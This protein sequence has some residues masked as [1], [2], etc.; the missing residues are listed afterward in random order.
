[1][2]IPCFKEI[3][4]PTGWS[5]IQK[6]LTPKNTFSMNHPP[7]KLIL[8]KR[9]TH[10][11]PP[12]SGCLSWMGGKGWYQ[13]QGLKH[14]PLEGAGIIIQT[15]QKKTPQVP[16][17]HWKKSLVATPFLPPPKKKSHNNNNVPP[18]VQW[19]H[20]RLSSKHRCCSL[21]SETVSKFP[22][23]GFFGINF[24]ITKIQIP[25]RIHGT[26][27]FAAILPT[28]NG[29]IYPIL[30]SIPLDSW[31]DS[32]Q[33]TTPIIHW[34]SEFQTYNRYSR[35]KF[36]GAKPQTFITLGG[37]AKIRWKSSEWNS[38]NISTFQIL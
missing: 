15:P 32:L 16:F 1:M 36:Q 13:S 34:I 30:C 17:R 18:D 8:K 35:P 11:D 9:K 22:W 7:N 31:S 20:T 25:H 37:A 19:F 29:P 14:N 5:K 23:D 10:L 3:F 24:C 27:I 4:Q 26:G 6:T 2:G 12:K 38:L 28:P 33:G 21:K